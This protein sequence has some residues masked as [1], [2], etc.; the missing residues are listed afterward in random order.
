MYNMYTQLLM[1][2]QHAQGITQAKTF[3]LKKQ[4]ATARACILR[5]ERRAEEERKRLQQQAQQITATIAQREATSKHGDENSESGTLRETRGENHHAQHGMSDHESESVLEEGEPEVNE[6]DYSWLRCYEKT[7]GNKSAKNTMIKKEASPKRSNTR[8]RADSNRVPPAM[9]DHERSKENKSSANTTRRA[10]SAHTYTRKEQANKLGQRSTHGQ[11]DDLDGE[12]A[13]GVEG[14][15]LD[16]PLQQNK[17]RSTSS[18]SRAVRQPT[19]DPKEKPSNLTKISSRNIENP[20]YGKSAYPSGGEFDHSV[21]NGRRTSTG[22]VLD[23]K[24][25]LGGVVNNKQTGMDVR[26][27]NGSRRLEK[28]VQRENDYDF[29]VDVQNTKIESTRNSGRRLGAT[30]STA[31]QRNNFDGCDFGVHRARVEN[32]DEFVVKKNAREQGAYYGCILCVCM[33]KHHR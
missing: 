1:H 24:T 12:Y 16:V 18:S 30:R 26:N 31:L 14:P 29:D 10:E 22:R 32:I 5:R 4:L 17:V 23:G 27:E 25:P 6:D 19:A 11:Y 13:G 15:R 33:Y 20:G 7:E 21:A 28:A 2:S 8:A 9:D 3:A